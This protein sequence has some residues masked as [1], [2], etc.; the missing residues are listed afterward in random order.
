MNY[1]E[2]RNSLTDEERA[3]LDAENAKLDE[4]NIAFR[5]LQSA[6]VLRVVGHHKRQTWI[7]MGD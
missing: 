5:S 1:E 4:G 7:W 6:D 3:S 2:M